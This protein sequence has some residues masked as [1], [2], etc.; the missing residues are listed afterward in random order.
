VAGQR[1]VH[2][3]QQHRVFELKLR[4]LLWVVQQVLLRPP[5]LGVCTVQVRTERLHARVAWD[6]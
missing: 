2:V 3:G 5:G 4:Q 1:A 6:E